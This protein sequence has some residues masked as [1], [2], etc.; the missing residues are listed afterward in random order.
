MCAH[1]IL[2]LSFNDFNAVDD[3]ITSRFTL[4]ELERKRGLTRRV[5]PIGA[6]RTKANPNEINNR[7]NRFDTNDDRIISLSVYTRL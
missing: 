3:V 1:V 4:L 6:T 7:L 2:S 5:K